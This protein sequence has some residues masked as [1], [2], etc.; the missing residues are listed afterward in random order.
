[1]EEHFPWCPEWEMPRDGASYEPTECPDCALIAVAYAK[2]FSDGWIDA[3]EEYAEKVK[4]AVASATDEMYELLRKYSL[5]LR[6]GGE[7][8]K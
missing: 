1:M 4:D 2:G 8:F 3:G 7:V 6:S 5:P